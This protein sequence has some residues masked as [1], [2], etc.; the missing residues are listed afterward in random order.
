ADASMRPASDTIVRGGG[1][2]AVLWAHGISGG[3]PI[4]LL[5]INDVE[6]IGIAR[7]LL[8]AHEYWRMKQLAVD[9]VIVN[10]RAASYVQDLQVALETQ[11]R[12][13]QS[14]PQLGADEARG[15]VFLLRMDLVP[16]QTHARLFAVARAGGVGHG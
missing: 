8:R 2:R 14:R 7:Q 11:L 4:V 1:E 10:E 6:D 3:L 16:E 13:S 12:V 9:L 5:R 15:A